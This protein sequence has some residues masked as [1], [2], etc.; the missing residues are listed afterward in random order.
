MIF[1]SDR[2]GAPQIYR[3]ELYDE[4]SLADIVELVASESLEAASFAVGD[5]HDR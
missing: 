4:T 2:G 3:L 5:R 1:T